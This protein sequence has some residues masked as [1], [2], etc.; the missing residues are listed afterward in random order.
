MLFSV[1]L[2]TVFG[3]IV[4]AGGTR[5][6]NVVSL[7]KLVVR[8][9]FHNHPESICDFIMKT[10]ITCANAEI[11]HLLLKKADLFCV[12]R[13]SNTKEGPNRLAQL[14]EPRLLEDERYQ[15]TLYSPTKLLVN[16]DLARAFFGPGGDKGCQGKGKEK[17][18]D[19]EPSEPVTRNDNEV[20]AESIDDLLGEMGGLKIS[21]QP[22]KEIESIQYGGIFFETRRLSELLVELYKADR[23]LAMHIVGFVIKHQMD[24]MN[25]IFWLTFLRI[26]SLEDQISV[27]D[28]L[29]PHEMT[30]AILYFIGCPAMLN[31]EQLVSRY[32]DENLPESELLVR[33]AIAREAGVVMGDMCSNLLGKTTDKDLMVILEGREDRSSRV[34]LSKMVRRLRLKS[35]IDTVLE[36]VFYKLTPYDTELLTMFCKL[37]PIQEAALKSDVPLHLWPV[38]YQP[39]EH[40]LKRWLTLDGPYEYVEGTDIP[41]EQFDLARPHFALNTYITTVSGRRIRV[42]DYFIERAKDLLKSPMLMMKMA[43]FE[44]MLTA[45][46]YLLADGGQ[47]DCS[48]FFMDIGDDSSWNDFIGKLD[49]RIRSCQGKSNW[50]DP[51]IFSTLDDRL[52]GMDDIMSPKEFRSLVDSSYRG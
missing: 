21:E 51:C 52:P 38:E 45:L 35:R 20:K 41:K 27:A 42:A 43:D 25:R 36:A 7:Q 22:S 23:E 47:L 18:L 37:N 44:L 11:I 46:G 5:D 6:G 13:Y 30:P 33:C 1:T 48:N 50:N 15:K 39:L 24:Y 4:L 26:A 16:P 9:L 32:L 17:V 28:M 14:L 31:G 49:K 2:L 8:S 29:T 19:G 10:D 34:A 3:A 40:R 12:Q